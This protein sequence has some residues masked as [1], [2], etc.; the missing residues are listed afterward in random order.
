MNTKP[1]ADPLVPVPTKLPFV[2]RGRLRERAKERDASLSFPISEAVEA[3]LAGEPANGDP[4]PGSRAQSDAARSQRVSLH[5]ALEDLLRA[6]AYAARRGL[7]RGHALDLPHGP[8]DNRAVR[9]HTGVARDDLIGGTPRSLAFL[10]RVGLPMF[11]T[12]ILFAFWVARASG[13][14]VEEDELLQRARSAGEGEW[15]QALDEVGNEIAGAARDD[16]DGAQAPGTPVQE[17]DQGHLSRYPVQPD[18]R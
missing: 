14:K 11:G 18:V 6:E 5:R 17:G 16:P 15:A 4:G 9:R 13:G 10:S 3:A 1:L 12:L 2:V 7:K 8:Q